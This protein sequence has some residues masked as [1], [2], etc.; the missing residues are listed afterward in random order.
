MGCAG[1]LSPVATGFLPDVKGPL[2]A[3]ELTGEKTGMACATTTLGLVTKGDA[4]F[5]AAKKA[6][7]IT[8][9]ASVDYHTKGY[10]P[11]TGETCVI[12]TGK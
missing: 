10:Y 11:F 7:G 5:K 1:G 3:T 4:S 6:G 12:V 8:V 2:P 9:V